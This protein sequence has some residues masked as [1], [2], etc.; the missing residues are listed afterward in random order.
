VSPGLRLSV[1]GNYGIYFRQDEAR[2]IVLRVLH[3]RRD[4]PTFIIDDDPTTH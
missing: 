4:I 3:F 2:L 1:F